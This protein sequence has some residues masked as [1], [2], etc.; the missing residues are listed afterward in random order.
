MKTKKKR[1]GDAATLYES[2]GSFNCRSYSSSPSYDHRR[3]RSCRSSNRSR[4]PHHRSSGRSRWFSSRL[5][6]PHRRS[7]ERNRSRQSSSRDQS[8]DR[9]RR[10]RSRGRSSDRSRRS[11][12]R[13][14]SS[15]R[16][17]WSSSHDRRSGRSDAAVALI[18]PALVH[19]RHLVRGL[20]VLSKAVMI[21]KRA[22]AAMIRLI[23]AHHPL[24]CQ[25]K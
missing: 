19:C 14:R 17:R 2:G 9:S 1:F 12:S 3:G 6:S 16:S 25:L 10:S 24:L 20:V 21:L 13:G 22:P 11:R 15:G 8:S 7:S 23:F 18:G 4:L 5:A